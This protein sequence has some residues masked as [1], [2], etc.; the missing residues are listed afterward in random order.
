MSAGDQD[1]GARRSCTAMRNKVGYPDAWRDYS[2][3][4]RRRAATSSATS[5][6][7]HG[8]RVA[9]A[10]RQ[11][12]QAR[13]PRRVGH[14]A[15]HRQRLLQPAD[16]RHQLPRGRPACRRST[17]RRWTTRPN[18]GNTGGTIGHELTHGFDD[19]GRQFDARGQ[20]ARLVDGGGRRGVREA[21]A[22]RPRPVRAVHRS[23]TT[24]RSTASSPRARTSPTSAARPRVDGLEGAT[25]A[26]QALRADGRP[27]ARAALLR[28]LRAVGL[29][30]TSAP[31]TPARE[32]ASP[33][34]IRRR[35]YRINGVVANMPEFAQA[36]QC[37]AGQAL[38]GRRKSSARC[39]SARSTYFAADESERCCLRTPGPFLFL[40]A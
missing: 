31:E 6:R 17:T 18:Y 19:E 4:R 14:D 21:R 37:K 27:H 5:T 26:R 30:A 28:R 25:K 9:P 36:F 20:P 33:T 13:G 22:V 12:R 7:A 34:R 16:E 35:E 32:R 39:G 24:S 1:A 8:L 29:R 15:A 3:L 10:A 23:S 38:V 40:V 2:A 11:D